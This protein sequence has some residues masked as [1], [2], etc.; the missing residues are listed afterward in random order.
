M[1]DLMS[2][3][4]N[5]DKVCFLVVKAREFDVKVAPANPDESAAAPDDVPDAV[6][7]DYG[8]DPIIQELTE[9]LGTLNGDELVSLVALVWLGRDDYSVSDWPE[10]RRQAAESATSH[11]AEYLLGVPLLADH[12]ENGLSEFGLSCQ[13]FEMGH[14]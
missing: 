3:D 5:I 11:T 12:L 13:D 8:D 4:I 10:V 9:F 1:N 14:L 2:P 7:S 6:L